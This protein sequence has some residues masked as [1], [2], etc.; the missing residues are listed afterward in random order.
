[1]GDIEKAPM[2]FLAR[3]AAVTSLLNEDA[4]TTNLADAYMEVPFIGRCVHQRD[5]NRRTKARRDIA[6]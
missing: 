1:M 3:P 2:P 4:V 5:E 6:H